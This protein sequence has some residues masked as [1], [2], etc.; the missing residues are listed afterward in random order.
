MT[1]YHEI[2]REKKGNIYRKYE[3]MKQEPCL[4]KKEKK[5]TGYD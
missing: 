4:A 2:N 1:Q 5:M 3:F